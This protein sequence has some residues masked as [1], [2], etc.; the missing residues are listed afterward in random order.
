L[1]R[2]FQVDYYRNFVFNGHRVKRGGFIE[3]KLG[4]LM[5]HDLRTHGPSAHTKYGTWI[6]DD[7]SCKPMVGHLHGR[8]FLENAVKDELLAEAKGTN[9]SCPSEVAFNG[10]EGSSSE[11]QA[12]GSSG[13]ELSADRESGSNSEH[14]SLQRVLPG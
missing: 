9:L 6:Y 10:S 2:L 5:L 4:S 1:G 7:R 3:D 14:Q 8:G 11:E 12:R 13:E